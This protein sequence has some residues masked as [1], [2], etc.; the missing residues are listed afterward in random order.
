MKIMKS[1][2]IGLGFALAALP[3]AAADSTGASSGLANPGYQ[4]PAGLNLGSPVPGAPAHTTCNGRVLYPSATGVDA[5]N[6]LAAIY[7][8]TP[9]STAVKLG[10][11]HVC[12][13]VT[14]AHIVCR[15]L[16]ENKKHK[17]K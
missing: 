4:P 6:Q 10:R 3:A 14:N 12:T 7:E 17:S 13:P 1:V 2:L 15:H 16:L 5:N 8:A 9:N 11:A